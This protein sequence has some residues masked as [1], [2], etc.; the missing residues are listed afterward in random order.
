M[1][2]PGWMTASALALLLLAAP[3]FGQG[4]SATL[5]GIVQD[6]DGNVP[7]ATVTLKNINTGETFP[8]QT[9]NASGAYS[10][11]GL[12]PGTYKVTITMTGFKTVEVETRLASGSTN[13]LPPT[14]L[15]VGKREE[16]V[17]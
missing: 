13:T 14:K 10:F 17:N 9:T 2:R 1:A 8:A 5:T 6:K 4:T 12:V 11:P 16:V 3:V 7:G 15:E